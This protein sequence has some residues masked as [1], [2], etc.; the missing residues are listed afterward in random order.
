MKLYKGSRTPTGCKVI[1][2]TGEGTSYPLPPRTDLYTHTVDGSLEWGYAGQGPSQLALALVADLTG[3][4]TYA[5]KVYQEFKHY[6]LTSL[7]TAEWQ[8]TEAQLREFC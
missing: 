2:T 8:F 3:D 7:E 6:V 5:L 1:V 4:D